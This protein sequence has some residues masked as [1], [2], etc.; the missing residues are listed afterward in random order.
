M[1]RDYAKEKRDVDAQIIKLSWASKYKNWRK[2]PKIV[3]L[4]AKKRELNTLKNLQSWGKI[5]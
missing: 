5:K 2:D 3:K 4:Q 1:A